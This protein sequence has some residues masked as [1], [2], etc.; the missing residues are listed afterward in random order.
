[1]Q[2][3]GSKL[4]GLSREHGGGTHLLMTAVGQYPPR[5]RR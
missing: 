4:R 2:E 3:E 1:M 5:K